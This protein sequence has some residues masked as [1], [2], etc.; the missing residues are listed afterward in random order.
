[1]VAPPGEGRGCEEEVFG[2]GVVVV[3]A[4]AAVP[5][6]VLVV[7]ERVAVGE[8]DWAVNEEVGFEV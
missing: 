6:V 7:M 1:M 3:V 8:E 5:V 4:V 2:D